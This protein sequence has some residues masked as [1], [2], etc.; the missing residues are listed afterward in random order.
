MFVSFN[1]IY[2]YTHT[3][4]HT[5]THTNEIELYKKEIGRKMKIQDDGSPGG[6]RRGEVTDKDHTS[7]CKL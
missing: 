3:H 2:C 7:D 4:T 6:R 1:N 5:H